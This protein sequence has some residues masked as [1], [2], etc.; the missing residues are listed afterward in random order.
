MLQPG[1]QT[2]GQCAMGLGSPQK[3]PF[4][5]RSHPAI[6]NDKLYGM[7]RVLVVFGAL[8]QCARSVVSTIRAPNGCNR[9]DGNHMARVTWG[10]HPRL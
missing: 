3:H 8:T 1:V 5:A 4:A 9:V 6:V 2:P 7:L 10:L